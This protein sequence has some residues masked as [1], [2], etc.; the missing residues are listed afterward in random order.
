MKLTHQKK[1]MEVGEKKKK[2]NHMIWLIV[3]NK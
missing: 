1:K 3:K 2:K